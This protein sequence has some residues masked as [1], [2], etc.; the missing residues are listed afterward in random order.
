MSSHAR[1]LSASAITDSAQSSPSLRPLQT[2]F[3]SYG[4]RPTDS[5]SEDATSQW[6]DVSSA[7]GSHSSFE[8]TSGERTPE[9][10]DVWMI[11][12]VP[13]HL[14]PSSYLSSDK[15]VLSPTKLVSLDPLAPSPD[16]NSSFVID[17]SEATSSTD[18]SPSF[19]EDDRDGSFL[20]LSALSDTTDPY[21]RGGAVSVQPMNL[22]SES[23]RSSV[24]TPDDKIPND[25]RLYSL[26]LELRSKSNQSRLDVFSIVET[27]VY[28][29]DDVDHDWRQ[30]HADWI[31]DDEQ[32][33]MPFSSPDSLFV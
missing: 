4:P 15:G 10:G 8:W 29:H 26:D 12:S 33:Q 5:D 24:I 7:S 11:K 16:P 23:R 13:L 9:A 30:F 2:N 25:S 20:S 1:S 19:L 27:D 6:A 31:Q 32:I 18:N 17:L 3:L 22:P 14:E 21:T 28:D